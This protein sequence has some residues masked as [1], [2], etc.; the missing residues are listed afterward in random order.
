MTTVAMTV[1]GKAVS[2]ETEDRALLVE[3]LREKLG[4]TGNACRLRHVAVRG[5]RGVG[6]RRR[7]QI[8]HDARRPGGRQQGG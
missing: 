8:L 7:G 3:V 4:L 1:N 6:R 5:L 2:V